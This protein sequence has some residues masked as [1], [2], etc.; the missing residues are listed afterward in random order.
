MF[1][2]KQ[3]INIFC[4]LNKIK[5]K[6][7]FLVDEYVLHKEFNFPTQKKRKKKEGKEVLISAVSKDPK[8]LDDLPPISIT[9]RGSRVLSKDYPKREERQSAD[10]LRLGAITTFLQGAT[11]ATQ[12]SKKRKVHQYIYI[13][14]SI[15]FT[16]S[17]TKQ[18]IFYAVNHSTC[19][20]ELISIYVYLYIYLYSS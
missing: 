5:I 9:H 6:V 8:P 20:V 14:I 10:L 17:L 18:T 1:L 2:E 12:M 16:F 19:K 15:S 11:M 4:F 13:Y 7:Y 3:R